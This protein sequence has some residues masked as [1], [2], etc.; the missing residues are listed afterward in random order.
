LKTQQKGTR[1]KARKDSKPAKEPRQ[2]FGIPNPSLPGI[3]RTFKIGWLFSL[4]TGE[5]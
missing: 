5:K 4:T 2:P 3:L 1:F